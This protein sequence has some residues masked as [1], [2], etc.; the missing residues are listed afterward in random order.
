A[1]PRAGRR[2]P[3]RLGPAP[4]GRHGGPGLPGPPGRAGRRHLLGAVAVP[5]AALPLAVRLRAAYLDRPDAADPR[6]G[7]P[8]PAGAGPA[9]GDAPPPRPSNRLSRAHAHLAR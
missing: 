7:R 9:G 8:A 3:L 1:A 2:G 4:R 6:P 5:G